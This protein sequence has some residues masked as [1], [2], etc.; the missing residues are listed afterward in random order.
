MTFRRCA[1][2]AALSVLTACTSSPARLPSPTGPL[3]TAARPAHPAAHKNSGNLYVSIGDSYAA[4]FQATGVGTGHTTRHGFADQVVTRARAK[5]YHLNLV[6]FG[7][8]GATTGSVLHSP[9]CATHYLAPGAPAYTQPQADAAEAFLR[10]HRGKVALI[11][12]SLGGNDFRTCISASNAASCVSSA[13]AR[14][15]RNLRS[16]VRRLRAA[17]P[18][19]TIVGTTYPDVFLGEAV[20]SSPQDHKLAP[21]SVL[22]FRGLINPQ[23]R[24]AYASAGGRF[25]DVTAA[26]DAYL[27]FARTVR[28]A[29]YGTVPLAVAQ[30]CRLTYYCQYEDIH[31][32]TSGYAVIARLVVGLLPKR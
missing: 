24:A 23:L 15:N 25:A 3:H 32:R 1:V 9:G 4:G 13:I 10:A 12:V 20:S 22:A 14:A 5:G 11:T 2:L 6:N 30:V 17:A 31:P 26:T 28:L 19:A 29:P 7:C 18:D 8:A 27:P 21:L 16:L